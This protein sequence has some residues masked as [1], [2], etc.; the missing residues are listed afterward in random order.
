[1][2]KKRALAYLSLPLAQ[3]IPIPCAGEVILADNL[4]AAELRQIEESQPIKSLNNASECDCKDFRRW[5][6]PCQ[7]MLELWIF[8]GSP[9]EP[10]WEKY[11]A[12]FDGQ[13]FDV[14]ENEKVDIALIETGQDFE[15][16]WI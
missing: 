7:H 2:G 16:S 14:Y 3:A 6:L 13:L 15:T 5:N 1:V 8:A 10:N 4:K 12:M 9:V 11:A